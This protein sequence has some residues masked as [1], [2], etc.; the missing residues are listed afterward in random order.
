MKKRLFSML[1]LCLIGLQSVFAQNREITGVVTSADD[2]LSIPGVS[3]IVKGTT[4]GT[5]TDFDGKYTLSVP[6]DG[7]ILVFSFVGMKQKEVGINSNT[8]NVVM[9]SES[10]GMDEVIVTGYGITKKAAFTGA[11]ST[12]GSELIADKVSSNPIKALEGSVAGLQLN[13]ESGQ[14][15]APSTIYIRGRNSLNSGTQPLY[16]ID[17]VSMEAGS[18]GARESEGSEFSPLS[19]INPNDIENITVLKDATATSIYGARA[20][21]GVIVIT[22]KKGVAGA[23]TKV[24]FSAKY[25]IEE[26][27]PFTDD[28]KT[29][30]ADEY[31]ELQIE[32]W[33]NYL[34]VSNEEAAKEY[35][36]G[37]IYGYSLPDQ[38][39]SKDNLA[40]VNWLD[41]ITRTGMVQEYNLSVQ[42]SGSEK[43]APRVYLSLGYLKNE[44]F[45]K[46]K[47]FERYSF[48]FN[49]DQKPTDWLSYG[50]NSS[51]SYTKTNMGAGGGYFSDPITQAY[52]QS[53]LTPVKDENGDWNF[54]TV[55]GYNPVAQRSSLGDKSENK[56]Y[57]AM[58]SPFLTINLLPELTYTTRIGLDYMS[59]G[60]FGYWSFLQPQGKDMR[61]MGENTN[62]DQTLITF[63]N[64]V[65]YLKTINESHNLNLLFGQEISS[66]NLNKAYLSGSN[67]PV[68]DKNVVS[69]AA[70]P[71]SASTDKYELRLA[72]FFFNGQYDYKSKYYL[73]ASYR[74]DGSSRFGENN[75]WAG[76][77]SVGGKYRL[78]AEDFM[79]STTDWLDNLTIRSSY[80]TSGNQA[81]GI[82]SGAIQ[83]GWYASRPLYGYGY[84]Y[85]SNGGSAAE[86]Y[87]NADLQWEQ[88]AKFNVGVDATLF[89]IFD[90]TVDY[91]KHLT[92]DMVFRV[93]MSFTSGFTD[94]P[95]NV[96]ELQNEGLEFS[97]NASIIRKA[98]FNWNASF[99]LSKNTNELTKLST[100]MPIENTY[101]IREVGH[102]I[103]QFKMKEFAGVDVQT[104]EALYYLNEKGDETTTNYNKASKRYLG[105]ATPDFQGSFSTNLKYKNFDLSV[106]MNYSVGGKIYGSNL[107]YDEQHGGSLNQSTTKYVYKNRWQNPGDVTNVPRFAMTESNKHSSQF[108]MDGDYLKIQNVVLGYTLPSQL[109]NSMKIENVRFYASASNLYTFTKSNYRGFDPAGV[110]AEGIQWWNYP[111]PRTFIFGVNVNF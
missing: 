56:T 66:T 91:Y 44:A 102:D 12:V 111:A 54:N 55:N 59:M 85:N 82:T 52:M 45:I 76:F 7:K 5:S 9:E 68:P 49:L 60:E 15:G 47:D 97:L 6:T 88:T 23:K 13:S 83:S 101:T 108:L 20:A 41:E 39:L 78:S 103:F 93:P 35:Y 46:G 1:I 110:G 61:G 107:R 48:R 10:I 40:D 26:I 28:Y 79:A 63:T 67:Y 3:V 70:T 72:S 36:D 64:T 94:L 17:G 90:V 104:G 4:I 38:G 22:T 24:S 80:G 8:I 109:T 11:A 89:S 106:Q 100:D 42:A 71:G 19:S 21:N 25:G 16:V 43:Y 95:M 31:N 51:L 96:G 69:L 98:D 14:P 75:R 2:G 87:G 73:S 57:R 92:K 30:N 53:P 77:W 27:A 33:Q 105:V 58:I 62:S 18:W 99:V 86:Q 81:V 29:V 74:Y 32:G 84:N 50:V 65:N 37:S 34:G